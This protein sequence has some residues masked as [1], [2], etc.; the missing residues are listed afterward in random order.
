MKPRELK[1]LAEK[2]EQIAEEG[3]RLRHEHESLI[4]KI[5]EFSKEQERTNRKLLTGQVANLISPAF[6]PPRHPPSQTASP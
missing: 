5:V 1:A 6:Q 4:K 2:A 3:K